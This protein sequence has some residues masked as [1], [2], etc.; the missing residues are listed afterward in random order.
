MDSHVRAPPAR[1]RAPSHEPRAT[2]HEPLTTTNRLIN[3]LIRIRE[4]GRQ[5]AVGKFRS[6]IFAIIY[7]SIFEFQKLK[8]RQLIKMKN[9]VREKDWKACNELLSNSCKR[10]ISSRK[11]HVN[12]F[13]FPKRIFLTLK[14]PHEVDWSCP[15][16]SKNQQLSG[17]LK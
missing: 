1:A 16:I 5:Q 4:G 11:H 15:I 3:W 14:W 12:I 9:R 6:C 2:N 13:V 10:S 8:I 7:S 17:F